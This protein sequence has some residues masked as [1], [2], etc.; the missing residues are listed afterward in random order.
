[1]SESIFT[2]QI[3]DNSFA[4]DGT[5]Y[6]LATTFTVAANG[7]TTHHR[8]RSAATQPS[9]AVIGVLFRL[10]SNAT[11]VELTRV[12]YD[13]WSANAWLTMPWPSPVALVTGEVYATGYITPNYFVLS[14]HT[15]TSAAITNGNLTAI[16]S[17]VPDA[18]GRI[19]VG[20]G[21]P[22]I[23]A[24]NDSSY[25]SDL[26]FAASS[27]QSAAIGLATETD[28]AIAM[29][30]SKARTLAVAGETDTAVPLGRS[31][32]RA[33]GTAGS[34]ETALALGRGKSRAL[35]TATETDAAAMLARAK[36]RAVGTAGETDI[37]LAFDTGLHGPV[38]GRI[39]ASTRP[40][41]IVSTGRRGRTVRGGGG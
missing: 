22:E 26:V 1:V 27:G 23:A 31:K 34:I 8:Y 3:P 29:G 6:T 10:T 37:A 21:F 7:S 38:G 4:N 19:H 24:F 33:V 40:G 35:G 30:R 41:R 15:F 39:V 17:G 13:N 14:E 11:G 9:A 36:A 25:F 20:D 32:A 2:T 5:L 16:Q 18:N 28:T 12:A